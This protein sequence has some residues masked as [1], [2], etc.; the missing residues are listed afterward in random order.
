MEATM[1]FTSGCKECED[2]HSDLA[3][4]VRTYHTVSNQY[5]IAVLR[6]DAGAIDKLGELGRESRERRDAARCA[7]RAHQEACHS[8]AE[9]RAIEGK[10]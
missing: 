4:A 10:T 6:R 8:Q 3:R 2:L 7:W 1:C 5:Q 9:L